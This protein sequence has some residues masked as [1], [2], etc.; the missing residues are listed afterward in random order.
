VRNLAATN[1]PNELP[2]RRPRPRG[3]RAGA[4]RRLA[5]LVLGHL[6]T[7]VA[8]AHPFGDRFTAQRLEVDVEPET[9][10]IRLTADVPDA[11]LTFMVPRSADPVG[12][13]LSR[14]DHGL[15]VTVDGVQQ[16]L[17]RLDH[18]AR[19]DLVQGTDH[20]LEG[21][22]Q[23]DVALAGRHQL[24]ITNGNLGDQPSYF[25]DEVRLP[26]ASRL[27]DTN[28]VVAHRG[29]AEPLHDA[30]SSFEGL[31]RIDL[32]LDVPTDTASTW[33]RSV[34]PTPWSIPTALLPPE[35][36][37]T[38]GRTDPLTL[39]AATGVAA[40]AGLGAS[41]AAGGRR[42]PVL[43]GA[44]ALLA[45]LVLG[46]TGPGALGVAMAAGALVGALSEETAVIVP[47]L[48]A[49]WAAAAVSAEV[50]AG[51]VAGWLVGAALGAVARGRRGLGLAVL[52]VASV[53]A[54]ARG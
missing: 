20:V 4:S 3:Q 10:V 14:L 29:R 5:L 27:L 49:P 43:A 6:G 39:A 12:E 26:P 25:R 8:H 21:R 41:L 9:V 31:R 46:V 28:L 18:A 50:A 16:P 54:A 19:V 37:W 32:E 24:R 22:W 38:A 1:L 52:A 36:A 45:S 17:R 23:A 51:P 30:W 15:V 40:I 33:F 35:R 11:L 13:V 53:V 34:A 48:A 44:L 47:V 7:S 42:G 2:A